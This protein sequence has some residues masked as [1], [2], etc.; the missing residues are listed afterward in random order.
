[1]HGEFIYRNLYKI[2][3]K[4]LKICFVEKIIVPLQFHSHTYGMKH[5]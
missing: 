5:I 2:Y 4:S 3:E 1:M